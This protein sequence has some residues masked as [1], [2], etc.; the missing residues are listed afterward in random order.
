MTVELTCVGYIDASDNLW[1]IIVSLIVLNLTEG[2]HGKCPIG[3]LSM[4]F[5]RSTS[6]LLMRLI[7]CFCRCPRKCWRLFSSSGFEKGSGTNLAL[8]RR[9]KNLMQGMLHI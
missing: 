8:P 6:S 7:F 1:R 3:P 5:R 9:V 2:K 4:L